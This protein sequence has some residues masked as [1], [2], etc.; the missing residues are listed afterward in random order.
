M[1]LSRYWADLSTAD[2]RDLDME[3]VIAVL[4]I[5]A[6]EQHGPHLPTGVD[7]QIMQG[8]IERVVERLPDDLDALF[9][10]PQQIGVSLE[11][12]DFPGT[13]TLSH[14]TA[15]RV[16]TEIGASVA[17][18]GC[19]KLVLLNS[20]GGNSPLLSQAALELRTR[21]ALLAVACSWH[22]FGY[23]DGLF[24]EEERKHGI[25]GGEIETSLMLAFRPELVDMA[26]A[27]N[28]RPATYD[29]ERD[30]TWLRSD[31]PIGFGWMTQDL[32]PEGAMGDAAS[33]SAVKGEAAA[34]YWATAFIELLRDVEAF[35]LSRLDAPPRPGR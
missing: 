22:R 33:A 15:L 6:I 7:A 9:L 1:P 10:P 31:R 4:P 29:F 30:F 26:R 35:D 23:P 16:V 2:F 28:F 14:E 12:G 24:G 13:L 8:A 18:A 32:S 11:H 34:D 21:H 25:H 5:A 20:H 17:R 27:R 3:R 19:R